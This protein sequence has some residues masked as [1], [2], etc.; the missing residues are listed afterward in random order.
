MPQPPPGDH[1][2]QERRQDQPRRHR[3]DRFTILPYPQ[4]TRVPDLAGHGR[5]CHAGLRTPRIDGAHRALIAAPHPKCTDPATIIAEVC[6]YGQVGQN[7]VTLGC[8][9]TLSARLECPDHGGYARSSGQR[10]RDAGPRSSENDRLEWGPAVV[11][12]GLSVKS[13]MLARRSHRRAARMV[14]NRRS[15]RS[16]V[17]RFSPSESRRAS[18]S[19][20]RR[21]RSPAGDRVGPMLVLHASR[22]SRWLRAQPGAAEAHALLAQVALEEGDLGKVTE[23]LNQ[24]RALGLPEERARATARGHPGAESADSPR[25]SRFWCACI[26]RGD[27][28]RSGRRRGA[29]A[30]LSDDLPAAPGR[31]SH[32]AVDSRRPARRTAVPVADGI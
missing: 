13:T 15:R 4:G 29:G 21:P 17:R 7:R 22:S 20:P 31:A 19:R 16:P 30:A 14:C 3:P 32:P 11:A 2:Q 25:Q 10:H 28:A 6:R 1:K 5:Y 9:Y 27:Q 26:N 24:A 18:G 12:K 23:E 8:D